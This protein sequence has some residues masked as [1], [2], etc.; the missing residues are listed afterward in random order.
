MFPGGGGG[1]C[2]VRELEDKIHGH[3]IKTAKEQSLN[4]NYRKCLMYT[5]IIRSAFN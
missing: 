1:K 2:M 5:Y 3:G 4:I